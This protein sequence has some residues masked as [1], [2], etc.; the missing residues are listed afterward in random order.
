MEG[1]WWLWVLALSGWVVAAGV[2]LGGRRPMGT[3]GWNAWVPLRTVYEPP[4]QERLQLLRDG[5]GRLLDDVARMPEA[6]RRQ[7][8]ARLPAHEAEVAEALLAGGRPAGDDFSG[9]AGKVGLTESAFLE[10]A[11]QALA[12]TLPEFRADRMVQALEVHQS[13]FVLRL[14]AE[15]HG[16]DGHR[17][18]DARILIQALAEDDLG[19]RYPFRGSGAYGGRQELQFVPALDPRARELRVTLESIR[20]L[21]HPRPPLRPSRFPQQETFTGE[22]WTF[23]FQLGTAGSDGSAG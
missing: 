21:L 3:T 8:L 4:P 10:R 6:A 5:V 17:E 15:S 18:D 9:L 2:V 20:K 12:K 11:S 19:Q 14:H 7:G 13:G 16:G 23:V 1:A 22:P